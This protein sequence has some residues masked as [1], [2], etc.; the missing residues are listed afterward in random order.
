MCIVGD[1][2]L[3]NIKNW[4]KDIKNVGVHWIGPCTVVYERPGK[5]YNIEYECDGK[6]TK[7]L[8]V[9]PEFLKLYLGQ[10]V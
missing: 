2:V 3:T 4:L 8:W 7:Y 1:V 10:V 5:P 6:I 9:H